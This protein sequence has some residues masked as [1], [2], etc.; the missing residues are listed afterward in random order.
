MRYVLVNRQEEIVTQADLTGECGMDEA[1]I[2][3][4][5]VKQMESKEDFLKLWTVMTETEYNRREVHNETLKEYEEFG[6]WLD[7]EKS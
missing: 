6:S 3:F 7:M 2:Y 1:I 5:G 4:Q